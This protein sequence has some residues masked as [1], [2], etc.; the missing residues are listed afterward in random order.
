MTPDL[1]PL[2]NHASFTAAI[3][4]Y[5]DAVQSLPQLP[6]ESARDDLATRIMQLAETGE[7]N[8]IKLR[9]HALAGVRAP[10]AATGPFQLRN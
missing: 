8:P 4:A 1:S 3:K 7:R 10:I 5:D 9:D 6:S 2:F